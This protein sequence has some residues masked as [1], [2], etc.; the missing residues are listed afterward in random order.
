MKIAFGA[1]LN[2]NCSNLGLVFPAGS[3]RLV[4]VSVSIRGSKLPSVRSL[5]IG[6]GLL[7]HNATKSLSYINATY[8]PPQQIVFYPWYPFH[9]GQVNT[10]WVKNIDFLIVE[11]Q[12]QTSSHSQYQIFLKKMRIS[13]FGWLP[14]QGIGGSQAMNASALSNASKLSPPG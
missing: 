5:L 3:A 11:R 13:I 14:S 1:L 10:K 12:R 4:W 6:S 8:F 9:N 7:D 2:H